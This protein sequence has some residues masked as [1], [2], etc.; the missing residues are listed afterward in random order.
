MG[1]TQDNWPATVGIFT[2][3]FAKE[4]VVGTLD[5]MYAQIDA[6]AAAEAGAMA[7]GHE[8]FDFWGGIGESFATIPENLVGVVDMLLDPLG[9]SV[10]DVSTVESAAGGLDV[11][12]G[13]FGAMVSL[14]DGKVGAF[15]YLLFILLYFPC[16]A[17]IAAVYRETNLR[18]TAFAGAWTTG[19]AYMASILFYQTATFSRHPVSSLLWIVVLCGLFLGVV[20]MMRQVGRKERGPLAG[21][22]HGAGA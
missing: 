17:A 6:A 16:G 22:P 21:L 9:I 1:I 19:L 18:W 7:S 12:L 14:F 8:R 4:T 20:M 15:A 5:A 13:T 11:S 2:G 10:G 3:V